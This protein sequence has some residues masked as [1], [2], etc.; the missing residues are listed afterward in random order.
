MKIFHKILKHLYRRIS[1]G[2]YYRFFFNKLGKNSF[3]IS[4]RAIDGGN[5]MEIADNVY[6]QYKT[7]LAALPLTGE[8]ECILKIGKG[9]VIGNFNH[10][11]ATKSIIIE[12][13]V[14]TADRVYISDNLHGYEDISSPI[15]KQPIVQNG[16]VVIGRGSWIGENVCIL[17]VKIGKQC[18]IGSNSV[19]TKDIPD[20]CVAA[21]IP[22]RIIKRYNFDT[23][24]WEKAN[25]QG[26]F[27]R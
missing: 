16:E 9:S 8:T 1:V 13:Y 23:N 25:F 24:Q 26:N 7:W 21:G 27:I 14:L 4:P 22:A 10:I 12:E 6:I 19:V 5:N 17:G 11:Y 15:L 20:Y 18:V 3:I 2:L